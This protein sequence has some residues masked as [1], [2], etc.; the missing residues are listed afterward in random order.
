MPSPNILKTYVKGGYYHIYNRGVAKQ[1]IFLDSKDYHVFLSYLKD[2]LIKPIPKSFKKIEVSFKG[3]TF[4]GI[5]RPVNNYFDK[6][7]L[8][9][10]CLMP[11]HFH[12][13]VQQTEISSMQNFM[14]SVST[15]Y[16]QYFNKRYD[17]IGPLFQGRYK[18]ALITDDHY[19]LHLS[20]YIHLNPLGMV[21]S[22]ESAYSSYSNYLG[23][24]N[25]SWINPNIVLEFFNKN[26]DVQFKN[27][28]TYKSFVEDIK[29][30][31]KKALGKKAIDW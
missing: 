27:N 3:Q 28:L 30:N 20:R 21:K 15:R 23:T 16:S 2:A 5:P 29:I 22:L 31:S 26:K 12:L 17:R 7:S 1:H 4:K 14:K 11:N 19:L 6:I 10:Y 24:R 25:T 13:V 18:A 8:V 9:C